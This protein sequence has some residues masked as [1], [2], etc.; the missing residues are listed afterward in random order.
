[1]PREWNKFPNQKSVGINLTAGVKYY[2][3]ALLKEGAS[4][5]HMAVGWRKPSDGDGTAPIEVIPGSVLSRFFAPDT[6]APS[7]PIALTSPSKTS[8]TINLS[9]TASTDNYGVA[10]YDVYQ[11]TIKINSSLVTTTTYVV[12]NLA[13]STSYTFTVKAKDAVGNTSPSSNALTVTTNAGVVLSAPR[14]PITEAMIVNESGLRDDQGRGD[15]PNLFDEQSAITNTAPEGPAIT[16]WRTGGNSANFPAGLIID[17]G[18]EYDISNIYWYDGAPMTHNGW[19]IEVKGGRIEVESGTPFNWT[20]RINQT[21]ANDAAWKNSTTTF[22]TRYIHIEKFSTTT[23]SW[24]TYSGFA[25]DAPLME[26]VIYGTPAGT[27]QPPQEPANT[28]TPLNIPMNKFIGGDS[29]WFGDTTTFKA[30]GMVRAYHPLSRSG[31]NSV[32]GLLDLQSYDKFYG[33]NLTA[34]YEIYPCIQGNF[35]DK[36]E[37]PTYG[38]DPALPETYRVHADNLWQW[39]ARYGRNANIPTNLLRVHTWQTKIAGL[40]YLNFMENWNEQNRWWQGSAAYF[41]PYQF[42]AMSSADYDGHLGTMGNTVGIKNADPTMKIMM[43][44]LAGLSIDYI[45]GMK[46]WSDTY[47]AGSF[48][49]DVLNFHHYSQKNINGATRGVSPESDNLLGRIQDVVDYR[50]KN[51]PG[52]EV[53]ISEFGWDVEGGSTQQANGHTQWPNNGYDSEHLQGIWLVRAFLIMAKAGVDR[54]QMYTIGDAGG[55]GLYNTCGLVTYHGAKRKSWYFLSTMKKRLNNMVYVGE[56]ASGNPN[57]LIYKF[58]DKAS[59]NG[60]YAIWSPTSDGTTVNNY[61]LTMN[62][63]PSSA[64][65]IDM[66]KGNET[67]IETSLSIAGNKVTVIVSEQPVFV[68]V[69]NIDGSIPTGPGATIT[70]QAKVEPTTISN[71]KDGIQVFPN[72][73]EDYINIGLAGSNSGT[74]EMVDLL[75]RIHLKR[76]VNPGNNLIDVSRLKKGMYLLKVKNGLT[77][78][79]SKIIIK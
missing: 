21:L 49:A 76:T 19:D 35:E 30:V 22:R 52:K 53:W 57:V 31:S 43:G 64:K 72:P 39:A 77:N 36:E 4:G 15:Y 34:G 79:Q 41:T 63:N 33:L 78:Y 20:T 54:A 62:A 67:G 26:M 13:P 16:H 40:G 27:S 44:G 5:D 17:L 70:S 59:N 18:R 45:K 58:K 42:A 12:T 73:T 32:T 47:R 66:V 14:I 68:S 7:A 38:G 29:W 60:V 75:G 51:L 9:W 37:K 8:A 48:P 3:E 74:A 71:E 25:A 55:Y 56:Q 10:G 50:N 69:N 61:Q 1:M 23:Y 2:I 24:S 65:K 6:Q 11:G 28:H 46:L